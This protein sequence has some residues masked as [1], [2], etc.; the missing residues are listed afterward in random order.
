M[1]LSNSCLPIKRNNAVSKSKS[2]QHHEI[3]S[4][5]AIK[6]NEASEDVLLL[7]PGITRQ[8]AHNIIQY[9]HVNDGFKQLNEVLEVDGITSKVFK[10]IHNDITIDTLTPSSSNK[11]KETINLNSASYNELRTVP[12]LTGNLVKRI[13]KRRDRKGSFRFIEDLLKIK[14]INY[15]ILAAARP[16]LTIDRQQMTT[17][18]SDSSVNNLYPTLTR[19]NHKTDT[20]SVASLLLETLPTELQTILISSPPRHPSSFHDNNNNNMNPNIFRF[21][22]WNLQQLTNDKVQNPGVREVICRVILANNFSLIGIQEIGN[23]EAL[24]LIIKELNSPTIPLLKDWPNRNRGNWKYTMS[25]VAG[26]MFQGSE[27]LGFLYNE[28]VGIELKQASLLSSK[29]YFTC[30]PYIT[31]FR[32]YNKYELVFVNIHLER[33]RLDDNEIKALSVLIQAMKNT[34]KQKHIIIFGDFNNVPTAPEFQ[35]LVACNY[36]YTIQ[37]NK[38]VSPKTTQG[39]TCVHNIWLSEEAK[40]LS[41]GNSGVI[42]D[43]LTSLWIPSGW[44]WGGLVSDHCPIWTEFDLS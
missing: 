30:S 39:S 6:I 5:N 24:D 40:A 29:T 26:Q 8:L 37:E 27:Y 1:G 13:I 9:R 16:Y 44:T 35:A 34:I 43:N 19:N 3:V 2:E 31:I 20:F 22:S 10:L 41:T 11:K 38:D 14:G 23:K 32:I 36:S 4:N 25:D 28:S 7:L 21:A 17:S 12:G 33:R 42:R 18:M 15:V